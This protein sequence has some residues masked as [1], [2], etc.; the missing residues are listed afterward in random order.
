MHCDCR[1]SKECLLRIYSDEYGA[2]QSQFKGEARAK[3]SHVNQDA[4]AL[5]ESGKCIKCGLCIQVTRKEREHYGLTFVG[6]GFDVKAGVSL[7][8]SLQEGLEKV[9]DDVVEACPT[10]ALAHNEE[11][12]PEQG[13]HVGADIEEEAE[14]DAGESGGQEPSS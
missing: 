2:K 8:K 10:G 13:R 7:D 9:A 12:Q 1:A 14:A 11:Y 3:H 6:R 5:Y 4:G